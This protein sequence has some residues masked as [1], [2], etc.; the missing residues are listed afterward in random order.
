MPSTTITTGEWARGHEIELIEGIQSAFVTALKTPQWDRD[1]VV[2]L[3]DGR[4]RIFPQGKSERFT[5][6]EITLFTG[7]SMEAKRNLY[8]SIV[9]N[10][11]VLGISKNEI[12]IV[13][14]EVPAH[15]WGIQG[16]LPASEVDI[17]F[18]V[19]V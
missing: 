4:R 1:I 5:R 17:G 7:R 11:A 10:L 12:K 8:R 16:G 6:I 13:L 2:A 3:Y 18:K 15:N 9:D 19:D 14:I